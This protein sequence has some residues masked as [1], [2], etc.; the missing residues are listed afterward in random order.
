MTDDLAPGFLVRLA[1][2]RRHAA[3]L[4]VDPDHADPEVSDEGRHDLIA[5]IQPQQAVVE[6]YAHQSVTGCLMLI[7]ASAGV[8]NALY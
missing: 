3:I 6:E 7:C 8:S 2:Q 1:G 5:F 4:G